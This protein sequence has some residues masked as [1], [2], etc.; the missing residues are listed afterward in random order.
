M[1]N[2]SI[3]LRLI[4]LIFVSV[5]VVLTGVTVTSIK[6]FKQ[7]IATIIDEETTE[8]VEFLNTLLDDHLATPI[9][10]VENTAAEIAV[11]NTPEKAKQVE[12]NLV[13]AARSINGILAFHAAYDDK[14]MYSSDQVEYDQSYDP[15]KRDW[16]IDAKEHAGE[17]RITA[18]YI[19]AITGKLIVGVSKTMANNQGVITLDL[20]LSFLEELLTS[21]NIGK[22]G[23]AFVL[24]NAGNVLYH[25]NYEQNESMVDDPAYE[26]FMADTYVELERDGTTAYLNRYHN[27]L[28]N[29]QIGSLY[30]Q[31][32]ITTVSNQ[33]IL[34]ITIVNVCSVFILLCLVYVM[35]SRSLKPLT[36]VT[37]FAEQVAQG[38]LKDRMTVQT[39]DEIGR[40]GNTFNEMTDGL[41]SM[42]HNVD[43][44]ADQLNAFSQELSASVE[45]NVQSIHQVVD[46]IQTVAD[47]TRDQ[48]KSAHNVQRAVTDMSDEVNIIADNMQQVKHSSQVAEQETTNGVSVISEVMQQMHVIEQSSKETATNFNE[49]I[50]VVNEIDKFS[51]VIADIAAQTNLLA[52]NASIEAA[53]AGEHGKGFAVVAEEV[54]KLAEETN[55]SAGEIQTLVQAIQKTGI[56]ANES[57]EDSSAAVT[58]GTHKIRTAN[59][60]FT[61]IHDVMAELAVKVDAAEQAIDMLQQRKDI[62]LTSVNEITQAT[63]LVSSNVDQVAATTEEQNASMEQIAVATES[64]TNQARELQASI[65]RFEIK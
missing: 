65:N 17:V 38:N 55:N 9:T 32:E 4:I 18:P 54:R 37:D 47:Q 49:L 51:Q 59:E 58:E 35:I 42:I 41:A 23:Y 64:L 2:L 30:T 27:E 50:T 13:L 39:N 34:P 11:A 63:R 21:I 45:E 62:A 31:K 57:M 36:T 15:T 52:L 24:D 56:A 29:W 26:P 43:G 1:R 44:T 53:R 5:T 48:L 3:K 14:K 22:E 33:I 46:N 61:L 12:E 19:D 28:M 6:L 7:H 10:L 20:D 40:L 25:P 16:Y 60:M 8:K